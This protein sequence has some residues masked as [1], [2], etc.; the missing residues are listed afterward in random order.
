M[1]NQSLKSKRNI[2]SYLLLYFI[3]PVLGLIAALR[4]SEEKFIIFAGTIFMG[5]IG[6]LYYYVPGND[7]F[8]HLQRAVEN[9][10]G[11]SFT[12][13]LSS[14]ASLLMFQATLAQSDIY[15][16]ILSYIS[17]TLFG[18]PELIHVLAGLVL[19]YFFT[20]S[21]LLIVSDQNQS[22]KT[23]LFIIVL[24][25][26]LTIRSITAI[27][28]IRMWTGMW[29]FFYGAFAFVYFKNPKYLLI[30]LL[31]TFIHFSY[32]LYMPPLIA[33]YFLM[34][35]PKIAASIY[36]LSWSFTLPFVSISP[37]LDILPQE[38]VF[39]SRASYS[40][41][42]TTE[43]FQPSYMKRDD[44]NFYKA[45]GPNIYR[46]YS[47]II[48]LTILLIFAIKKRPGS[49]LSFL[50]VTGTMFFSYVN[51]LDV[52]PSAAG[53]GQVIGATFTTA[54]LLY[55]VSMYSRYFKKRSERSLYTLGITSFLIS[56]FPFWLFHISYTIN[57][58]SIYIAA[59]PIIQWLFVE[60][61]MSIRD[62]LNQFF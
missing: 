23:Y 59:F 15:S 53:R 56:A 20:K 7:G 48:L 18:I 11:L 13:F 10:D 8:T 26:F 31:S 61:D 41:V 16:H 19:G 50:I 37:I 40:V 55:L 2:Y 25:F 39:E 35:K 1:R 45:Y 27:N 51:I 52:V 44:L 42:D 58:V 32:Y 6:S 24:I 34:N 5:F 30:I 62:F 22:K 43:D 3:S 12:D 14:S 46:N 17:V 36:I 47:S 4:T 29:V 9:Y 33:A 54:A 21:V 49:K 57:I 28:S 60:E 38:N